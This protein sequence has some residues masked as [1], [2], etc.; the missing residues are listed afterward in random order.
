[1][2]ENDVRHRDLYAERNGQEADISAVTPRENLQRGVKST[3]VHSFNAYA[4][5]LA[6]Q[7]GAI[8]R[9]IRGE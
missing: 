5:R 2:N 1:M 6:Q 8:A 7:A 9:R 3:P 4:W